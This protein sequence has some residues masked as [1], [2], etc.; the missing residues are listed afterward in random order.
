M[1]SVAE[2]KDIIYNSIADSILRSEISG[3]LYKD[4]RPLGSTKEDIVVGMIDLSSGSVQA[5]TIN[6]NIYVPYMDVTIGGLVQKKPNHSRLRDLS[7]LALDLLEEI[8]FED[9]SAWIANQ[10][11]IKEPNLDSMFANFRM[12]IRAHETE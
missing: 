3:G 4:E 12:E 5:G 9:C 10:A 11:E 1:K 8:Y 7:R 6:V 2:C